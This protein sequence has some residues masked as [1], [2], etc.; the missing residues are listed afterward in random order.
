MAT[1]VGTANTE[2]YWGINFG[3][4]RNRYVVLFIP[5]KERDEI[6]PLDHEMWRNMAVQMLSKLF[7]GATSV[8]GY[9]GWLD[10]NDNNKV[11]EEDI[12]MVFSFFG[13]DEWTEDNATVVKDFLHKMGREAKQGAVSLVLNNTFYRIKSKNYE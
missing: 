12:S 13:E 10:E 11:K 1:S 7:E 3:D 9:G 8:K 5:S 4:P 2:K 6:T